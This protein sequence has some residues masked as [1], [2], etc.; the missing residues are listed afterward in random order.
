MQS[1]VPAGPESYLS[2]CVASNLRQ[3]SYAINVQLGPVQPSGSMTKQALL[4]CLLATDSAVALQ[5]Q[6]TTWQGCF[7]SIILAQNVKCIIMKVAAGSS[8]LAC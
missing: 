7:V 4:E 2:C 8:C 3:G 1:L 5:I 6:C